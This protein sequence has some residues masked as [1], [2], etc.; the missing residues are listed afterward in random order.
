MEKYIKSK[1]LQM[2]YVLKLHQNVS[3]TNLVTLITNLITLKM[4]I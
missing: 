1:I 4:L 3:I 2:M